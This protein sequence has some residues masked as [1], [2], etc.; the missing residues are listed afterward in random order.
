MIPYYPAID[1]SAFAHKLWRK[2]EFRDCLHMDLV[3]GLYS[4]QEFVKRYMAPDTPYRSILLFHKTGSGKTFSSIAISEQYKYINNKALILIKGNT[5]YDTFKQELNKYYKNIYNMH[6]KA[7]RENAIDA[8]YEIKKYMSFSKMLSKLDDDKIVQM[9]SNRVIIIDEIHHIKTNF[10]EEGEFNTIIYT[11]IWKM[12]HIVKNCKL[13]L[14]SATPMIDDEQE[15]LSVLNLMLDKNQQLGRNTTLADWTRAFTGRVSYCGTNRNIAFIKEQGRLCG[16]AE[17]KVVVS[18]MQDHQL[19]AYR[20]SLE[21]QSDDQVYRSRIYASLMSFP[22]LSY[23]NKA[24]K[25]LK[26][27]LRNLILEVDQKAI[28]YTRYYFDV[29]TIQQINQ[30]GLHAFSCKYARMLQIIDA[31]YDGLVFVFCEEVAGSG[32]NMLSAVLEMHGYELYD[33]QRIDHLD[34]K[35]RYTICTGETDARISEERLKWFC[36]PQNV[37]GEYVRILLG[38]KVVGEGVNLMNIRQVHILTPHWNSSTI[39]Q[40]VG[41]AI[42]NN[43]H[44]QLDISKQHLAI[45]RHAAVIDEENAFEK[46]NSIDLYKYRV[47]ESKD[48]NIRQVENA[49]RDNA[50]DNYATLL[51]DAPV[52]VSTYMLHYFQHDVHLIIKEIQNIMGHAHK[53]HLHDVLQQLDMDLQP[54]NFP[55]ELLLCAIDYAITNNVE[56]QNRFGVRCFLRENADVLYLENYFMKTRCDGDNNEPRIRYKPLV[57]KAPQ[58][59]KAILAILAI[60]S[61]PEAQAI[62]RHDLPL[63]GPSLLLTKTNL[64]K[65]N[66]TKTN[67][68]VLLQSIQL[69]NYTQKDMLFLMNSLNDV[70]MIYLLEEAVIQNVDVVKQF[71]QNS[72]FIIDSIYYHILEYKIVKNSSYAVSSDSF[73]LTGKM[74]CFVDNQ[75][76]YVSDKKEKQV[77]SV[78]KEKILH[79]K[80]LLDE[81]KMFA[82]YNIGDKKWRIRNV[83]TE[84]VSND[85]RTKNRGRV[86]DNYNALSLVDMIVQLLEMGVRDRLYYTLQ[87]EIANAHIELADVERFFAVQKIQLEPC[88]PISVDIMQRM[89]GYDFKL[90]YWLCKKNK[91]QLIVMLKQMFI[92]SDL[93]VVL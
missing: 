71:F 80:H 67:F 29:E 2:K 52:D 60:F 87:D 72:L 56:F 83:L 4:H 32:L 25:K 6:N 1:E 31:E 22:D 85:T 47:A 59:P 23:G 17:T 41:R 82:I 14:L 70:C 27:E 13:V 57:P 19:R 44:A 45:Y 34:K 62:T 12:V 20:A 64:T 46:D 5:A 68:D 84:K 75:W 40:A 11:Q 49:M 35:H 9:F 89:D 74:R 79:A 16:T 91:K 51:D 48:C 33:G 3:N 37:H 18:R 53:I 65:T 42:R 39:N 43:S 36:S 54:A 30:I 58:E 26:K 15:I 78:I 55:E 93:Y 69:F 73:K 63:N 10:L 28:K 90:L 8:Y 81:K 50:V 7:E 38:S 66:L 61:Q 92:D 76:H 88:T 77:Y 21:E 24:Y 86:M